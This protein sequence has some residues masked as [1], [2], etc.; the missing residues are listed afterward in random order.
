MAHYERGVD[1]VSGAQRG[2]YALT[3]NIPATQVFIG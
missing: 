2:S 3:G 1:V